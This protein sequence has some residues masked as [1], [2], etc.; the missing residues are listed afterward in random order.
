MM[1]MMMI[2]ILP[3]TLSSSPS[4]ARVS[5]MAAHAS[6]MFSKISARSPCNTGS[7]RPWGPGRRICSYRNRRSDS[8]ATRE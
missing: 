4:R 8:A 6:R 7:D 1:M 2:H 5:L 3:L